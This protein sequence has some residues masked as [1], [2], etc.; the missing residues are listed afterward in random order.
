M[1]VAAARRLMVLPRPTTWHLFVILLDTRNRVLG[2]LTL[3]AGDLARHVSERVSDG[4]LRND[5]KK[6]WLRFVEGRPVSSITT[7]FLAW[8][9][10][11]LE[12]EGKKAWLLIWDNAS[13]HISREVR[14]WV[15]AHNRAAKRSGCWP[16]RRHAAPIARRSPRCCKQ[17]GRCRTAR[18]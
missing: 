14:S 11:R 17:L 13:W 6:V 9:C 8:G 7:E 1:T 10:A 2:E 4:L 12:M 15:R 16:R 18:R 5:L 3:R